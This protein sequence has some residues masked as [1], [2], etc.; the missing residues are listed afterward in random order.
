MFVAQTLTGPLSHRELAVDELRRRI[1]MGTG[2]AGSVARRTSVAGRLRRRVTAGLM[3]PVL[4]AGSSL[5][6]VAVAAAAV[7]GVAAVA[8]AKAAP[9]KAASGPSVVV[10]L[11][12]GETTAPETTV[13]EAAGDS[14]TQQTPAQWAADS[15]AYF[16]GFAAL[17]IGDPSSGSCSSLLP[18]TGTAGSG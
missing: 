17:V 2:R 9:A 1:Q 10:L 12:N 15:T 3:G 5:M 8:V 4:A 13:L 14:V 18:V 16:T 7:A 11:Q 6:P